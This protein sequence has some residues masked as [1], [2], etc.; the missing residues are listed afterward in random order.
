MTYYEE[1]GVSG[2]APPE[3]LRQAYKRLARLI[4]PDQCGDEATRRLADLQLMRL[5]G[6]LD[7]LLDPAGRA[8]YDRSLMALAAAV[9][10]EP[11]PKIARQWDPRWMAPGAIAV[12]A[13]I[14]ILLVVLA[15][16][17]QPAVAPNLP[18]IADAIPGKAPPKVRS[19]VTRPSRTPVVREQE[20]W[21]PLVSYAYESHIAIPPLALDTPP[22]RP[23]PAPMPAA[24]PSKPTLT[25]DLFF[26]PARS[27]AGGGY[28]PEY[29]EL[30]LHEEDGE[31]HGRYQARYRVKDQAISPSVAFQFEGREG[32]PIEW[33]GASGARGEVNLRLL[34]DGELE[35]KWEAD[36]LGEM[37][38]V[39]GSARLVRKAE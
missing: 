35:V 7:T 1:L 2:T 16:P 31:L 23:E 32:G 20:D 21:E 19:A 9:A 6:I 30:R 26:V 17:K 39:S 27:M 15:I 5:N 24:A 8:R 3:E 29:I 25:G 37:G 13:S 14:V 28:P 34:P 33:H 12:G 36:Q 4:H 11:L 18:E 38:L 10:G 22:A